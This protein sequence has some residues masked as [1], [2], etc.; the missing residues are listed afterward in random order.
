MMAVGHFSLAWA[1]PGALYAGSL[2]VGMG[3]GAHWAIVPATASELFG[4]KNFGM[5][6]NFLSIATPVGS[7]IFSGLIAGTLYDREAQKQQGSL[8][9]PDVDA[10]K[11]EGAVCFR[12]TLFIMTGVC[13]LGVA[14]NSIL[15]V[16]TQRVYTTLYAKQLDDES[17]NKAK[18]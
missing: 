14:L 4:L 17:R 5:L 16:R 2:M 1:L 7:L 3:Y 15:I 12:E 10:L 6:Y 8:V 9:P 18:T 13:M 11:C